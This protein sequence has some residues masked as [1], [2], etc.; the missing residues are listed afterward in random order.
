MQQT[1]KAAPSNS[2]ILVMDRSVCEIPQWVPGRLVA[3]TRTCVAV[4]TLA[5]VDGD[6]SISLQDERPPLGCGSSPKF[7]GVIFTPSKRISV[8]TVLDEVLLEMPVADSDTHLQ[9]W[10]NDPSEPDVIVILAVPTGRDRAN[11][12]DLDKG[13]RSGE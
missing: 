2:I 7:D 10:A 1:I 11:S 8:C 5:D 3:A 13:P 6:T 4:G 12:T 9:V